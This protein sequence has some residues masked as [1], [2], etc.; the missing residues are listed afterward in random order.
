MMS[1]KLFVKLNVK[2]KKEMDNWFMTDLTCNDN[3]YQDTLKLIRIRRK[4]SD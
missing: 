3:T 2:L 4:T 1:I